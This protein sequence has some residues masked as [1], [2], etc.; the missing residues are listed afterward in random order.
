MRTRSWAFILSSAVL[1]AL[2]AC[3][4]ERPVGDLPDAGTMNIGNDAG[5]SNPG[6]SLT[7]VWD[8]MGSS[9]GGPL[10]SVNLTLDHDTIAV[11]VDQVTFTVTRSG[12]TWQFQSASG[13]DRPLVTGQEQ[14][15]SFSTGDL[16]L[17]I[18]GEW[19][20]S[21]TNPNLSCNGSFGTNTHST[22]TGINIYGAPTFTG[23]FTGTRM[24]AE[25]SIFGDLGGQWMFT[26]TGGA[27]C[28]VEFR[29]SRVT[30]T[31]TNAGDFTGSFTAIFG[32][33]MF[34]GSTVN[35]VEFSGH[36]R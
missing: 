19:S 1:A 24:Q 18:G 16:A 29:D 9:S 36:R 8:I 4:T 22:C 27:S 15:S 23:N 2:T 10:V 5:G 13:S 20:L 35:G 26:D 25:S 21:G 7:G 31:C 3:G 28:T 30:Y 6:S 32:N 11:V 12:N 14:P 34:S 33:G 17:N